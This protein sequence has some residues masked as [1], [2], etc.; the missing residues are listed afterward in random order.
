MLVTGI[1]WVLTICGGVLLGV[2][3][4]SAT[5]MSLYAEMAWPT[6]TIIGHALGNS[7]K[8][9]YA[10]LIKSFIPSLPLKGFFSMACT[11]WSRFLTWISSKFWFLL[12]NLVFLLV[13]PL[14]Y[15]VYLKLQ[16]HFDLS[17]ANSIKL[18]LIGMLLDIRPVLK[19][20]LGTALLGVISY[21]MPALLFSSWSVYGISLSMISLT[22]FYQ[23]IHEN[24]YPN[25]E[26][27]WLSTLLKFYAYVMVVILT[28]MGLVG[29]DLLEKPASWSRSDCP[30]GLDWSR[31]GSRDLLSAGHT[32]RA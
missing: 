24:W 21:Y 25:D 30:T 28:I 2:G 8:K 27:I 6:R 23:N 14:A 13:A 5:I 7:S 16:V 9:I 20:I 26:K 18:S 31:D 17:Y 10:Q 4:A 3:P 15:A 12:F 32:R 1:F 19:L 29:G 11:S 22:L